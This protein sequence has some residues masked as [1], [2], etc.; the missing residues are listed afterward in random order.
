[1]S[2][3]NAIQERVVELLCIKT[4]SKN[5]HFYRLLCAYYFSKMASMLRT[6]INTRERGVICIN[7][8]VVNLMLSGE[9]KGHSTNI[10]EENLINGFKNRFMT[11]IFPSVSE[12]HIS[13]IAVERANRDGL[14]EDEMFPMVQ[15]EF[16]SLGVLPFSFDAATG[17]ALKQLRQLLL[18]AAVGSM[19]IEIDEI[20]SNL[21]GN[22]EALT[23]LFELYDKGLVKPKLIKNTRESIRMEDI[24]GYTPTNLMMF[25]TPVRLLDGGKTEE[26]FSNLLESGYARRL[27]FGFSQQTEQ[28]LDMT[29]QEIYDSLT[30]NGV[31]QEQSSLRQYFTGLASLERVGSH[32]EMKEPVA[33]DLIQ[34]EIDC[35][36]RAT[37]F[38]KYDEVA[39][40]EMVHRYFKAMKLAGA[41]A[42]I[43]QQDEITQE[44]LIHAINLVEDSGEN[45]KLLQK[46]DAPYIRLAKY[47]AFVGKDVT[48]VDLIE[49]L[50]FF[51]G[52]ESQRKNLMTL[53]ITYGYKNNIVI[54]RSLVDDIEFFSGESLEET[55]INKLIV[56][57]SDKLAE[58]YKNE[59]APFD[60]LH[61]MTQL[62]SHNFVAHHLN[63][64]Y[65]STEHIDQETGSNM[66]VID[67]DGGTRLHMAKQLLGE[68]KT[69]I[70][71]TK[72]HTDS[73]NR[74]RVILPLSHVV[75][76]S[77]EDYRQFMKN[78]YSWLPFEC[79]EATSDRP[80]KWLTSDGEFHYNDGILL[81]VTKFIPRTDKA[82]KQQNTIV[83]MGDMTN[84]ERWFASHIKTGNRNIMLLRFGLILLDNNI[85]P[86]D[87][88][89]RLLEFN[90]K[91]SSP[92][93]DI[94]IHKTVMST[95]NQRA[96]E[97]N[98]R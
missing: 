35:K 83:S 53:A 79:D 59:F 63:K 85:D 92:V 15:A 97:K 57:H 73:K 24:D 12:T 87:I 41:Y 4:R 75:K 48:N 51:K 98:V 8:Y 82:I 77:E 39:K 69:L 66:C 67:V 50:Q 95:I 13:K 84:M 2:K 7:T 80:R 70:Y 56:S 44:D 55:D 52:T 96:G 62:K 16:K 81:D 17:P 23:V 10:I 60:Q 42:F 36:H 20:G 76:L 30:N 65:R 58:G 14:E 25:G 32:L 38:S 11:Q 86:K 94:E 3:Y 40:A 5:K 43:N 78:I 26:E 21:L 74:F 72:R 46:R 93:D 1:M 64:G 29:A 33:I 22:G 45:F 71:T 31:S 19:N 91:L 27:L 18:M 68:Y 90:G 37:K 49:N 9:G 88:L 28:I 34:Y 6:N 47:L 61:K 54:K 89:A